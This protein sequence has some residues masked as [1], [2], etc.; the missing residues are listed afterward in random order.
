M[1]DKKVYL[2]SLSFHLVGGKLDEVSMMEG[3]NRLFIFHIILSLS[4]VPVV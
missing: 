3:F 1:K 2:T 4:F